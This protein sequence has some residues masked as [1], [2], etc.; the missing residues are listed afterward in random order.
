VTCNLYTHR[1]R[2]SRPVSL[3]GRSD[4]PVD[5]AHLCLPLSHHC[6]SEAPSQPYAIHLLLARLH[7]RGRRWLWV[8]LLGRRR[9]RIRVEAGLLGQVVRHSL[10]ESVSGR[11]K[12]VCSEQE[13]L[14][15]PLQLQRP[16]ADVQK[17]SLA[18]D[19][20]VSVAARTEAPTFCSPI[21][22]ARPSPQ[23]TH[24]D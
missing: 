2:T 12:R 13:D 7:S 16:W 19:N 18:I 21:L 23:A 3:R 14:Q 5:F 9:Q 24:W 4:D 10:K 1:Q 15:C 17:G 6:Q 22:L 11:N 8:Q 20:L